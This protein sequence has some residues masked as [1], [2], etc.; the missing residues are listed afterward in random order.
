MLA[1]DRWQRA[2]FFEWVALYV[3]GRVVT[4]SAG[5]Q[6]M[7]LAMAVFGVARATVPALVRRLRTAG[8]SSPPDPVRERTVQPPR[9]RPEA[10]TDEFGVIEGRDDA[11]RS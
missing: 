2:S 11:P 3:V 9:T 4:T 10:P 5:P 1:L 7:I 6:V 8:A